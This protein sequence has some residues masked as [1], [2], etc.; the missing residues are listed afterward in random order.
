MDNDSDSGN[1]FAD[2]DLLEAGYHPELDIASAKDVALNMDMYDDSEHSDLEDN[3]LI[4]LAS[5][6]SE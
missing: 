2:T 1:D 4:D 3:G 6:D 5:E